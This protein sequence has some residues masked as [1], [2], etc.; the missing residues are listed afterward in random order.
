MIRPR[1]HLYNVNRPTQLFDSRQT[2]DRL[3]MNEYVPYA[4]RV[5]YNELI[6]ELTPE[7]LSGYP[8][9]NGAYA[10]ISDLTSL[11]KSQIVLTSGAD[12]VLLSTFQAFCSPGDCVA[13]VTPTYEMYQ[14]YADILNL[15][16]VTVSYDKH[17]ELDLDAVMK[18]VSCDVSVIVIANPNGCIG[19]DLDEVFLR[20]LIS[21]A[22]SLGV[23][24]LLD[25]VYADYIDFGK[26]RFVNLINEYDNLVIARSF[27]KGFGLAGVRVGYSIS[28]PET[29][30]FLIAVR[31]NVEVNSL[32][33]AAVQVWC[34]HYD[35]IKKGIYDILE[36]KKKVFI[37]LNKLGLKV[38]QGKAN[39]LLMRTGKYET[40]LREAFEREK[41]AI[42]YFSGERQGDMRVTIGTY[43]YMQHF[44]ETVK[45]VVSVTNVDSL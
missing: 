22:C 25:E 13:F 6:S 33:A 23:V 7:S 12:G 18:L 26:S 5:L 27:S 34:S 32:A 17:W 42:K 38:I 36:S 9:V 16:T 4:P 2:I 10:A 3:D 31:N 15:R 44:L 1:K 43:E 11:D 20:Q 28:C 14:V 40:L 37:E 29:R 8:F 21:R 39:F 41:I 19:S 30:H 24:V 35:T 45:S